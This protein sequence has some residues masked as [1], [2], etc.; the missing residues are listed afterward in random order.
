[1]QAIA[2][3]VVALGFFLMDALQQA[4]YVFL[5]GLVAFLP[6]LYF[7]LKILAVSGSDAKKIVRAFY[8][9]ESGKLLLTAVLF[10]LIL[11]VPDI[12]L[13]PV[14]IGFVVTLS[15]FWF[16]LMMHG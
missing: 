3:V 14:M 5:G 1:M 11:Q 13:L 6:N 2:L 12:T 4:I 8:V 16:A 15:V 9:G 7:G 10:Y